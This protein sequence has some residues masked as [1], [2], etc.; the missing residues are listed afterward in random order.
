M[1]S[2]KPFWFYKMGAQLHPLGNLTKGTTVTSGYR[3]AEAAKD[4]LQAIIRNSPVPFPR[5]RERAQGLVDDIVAIFKPPDYEI[6]ESVLKEFASQVQNLEMLMAADVDDLDVFRV[7]PLRI[8]NTRKLLEGADERLSKLTRDEIGEGAR[9]DLKE[10]GTCLAFHL[11]TAAGF[12][13][14]RAVEGVARKY[15]RIITRKAVG[16]DKT[17]GVVSSALRGRYDA[18]EGKWKQRKKKGLRPHSGLGNIAALLTQI[19]DIYRNPIIHPE[20]VLDADQSL[21]VFDLSCNAL[22]AME[23]DLAARRARRK[24]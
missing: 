18:E 5:C 12:H 10:A 20:M 8:Y 2:L 14:V 6:S 1:E 11:F 22:E 21:H 17:L 23:G 9:D 15:H 19:T 4:T 13:A 16:Y 7:Q 3:T 24:K